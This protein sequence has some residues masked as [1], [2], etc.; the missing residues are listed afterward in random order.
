MET[1]LTEME[2]QEN[3][4]IQSEGKSPNG[5]IITRTIEED[6]SI[7]T[8]GIVYTQDIDFVGGTKYITHGKVYIKSTYT[9]GE[10]INGHPVV[11]LTKVEGNVI[12]LYD[13][14]ELV[15]IEIT[16]GQDCV[17]DPFNSEHDSFETTN[18]YYSEDYNWPDMLWPNEGTKR[19]GHNATYTIYRGYNQQYPVSAYIN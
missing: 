9:T 2:A 3:Q 15:K 13:G 1:E 11:S 14:A 17:L 18:D 8:L 16:A 4:L 5:N 7:V 10:N 6:N 19:L 12:E